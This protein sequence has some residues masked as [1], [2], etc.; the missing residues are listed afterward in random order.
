[1]L[2]QSAERRTRDSNHHINTGL[3]IDATGPNPRRSE[4]RERHAEQRGADVRNL[5]RPGYNPRLK[6]NDERTEP[7]CKQTVRLELR[8]LDHRTGEFPVPDFAG[9]RRFN[10]ERHREPV[11][12]TR[13]LRPIGQPVSKGTIASFHIESAAYLD[14]PSSVVKPPDTGRQLFKCRAYQSTVQ[15]CFRPRIADHTAVPSL[16]HTQRPRK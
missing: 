13:E 14:R 8:G 2:Y 3:T 10:D 5:E 11:L 7:F 12:R 15:G 6:I 9:C 16:D 4:R 1:M